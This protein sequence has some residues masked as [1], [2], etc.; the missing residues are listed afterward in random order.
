MKIISESISAPQQ[1]QQKEKEVD[2]IEVEAR[3]A[4]QGQL[5]AVLAAVFDPCSNPLQLLGIIGD[6]ACKDLYAQHGNAEIQGR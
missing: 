1:A 2:E 6:E 5:L 4:Q 3:G